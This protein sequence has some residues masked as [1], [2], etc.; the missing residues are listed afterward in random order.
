MTAREFIRA[1][2]LPFIASSVLPYLFGAAFGSPRVRPLP[3]LLGLAVV[4]FT[5]LSANLI[6]DWAGHVSGTDGRE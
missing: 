4:A 2:R 6:N 1:F 5:H 3:F